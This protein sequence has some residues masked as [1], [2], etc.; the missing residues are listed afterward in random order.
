MQGPPSLLPANP[1]SQISPGSSR[2]SPQVW[3]GPVV[4]VEVVVGVETS[5]VS[6]VPDVGSMSPVVVR[7]ASV[8]PGAEVGMGDGLG[9]G[10]SSSS[11]E[12]DSLVD[13]D[14]A[15]AWQPG[16]SSP[17]TNT[18]ATRSRPCM[19]RCSARSRCL[20][21]P[22]NTVMGLTRI[23][24]GDRSNRRKLGFSVPMS[25]LKDSLGIP[26]LAA[27]DGELAP[28]WLRSPCSA[29]SVS[30]PVRLMLKRHCAALLW[31]RREHDPGP[32][33]EH[34]GH[35]ITSRRPSGRAR[36]RRSPGPNATGP[37]GRRCAPAGHASPAGGR[38]RSGARG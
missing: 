29:A 27:F 38:R 4:P 32:C 9:P 18:D 10:S 19:P 8:V 2:P 6:L 22:A 20:S 28:Q 11:L 34:D 30:A 13:G 33:C 12:L 24:A 37:A 26:G 14:T 17:T 5:P 1:R 35:A 21:T 3:D 7:A 36:V 16:P 31:M 15:C 25:V 23:V